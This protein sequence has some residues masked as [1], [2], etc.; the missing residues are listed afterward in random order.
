MPLPGV[1]LSVD[2][3]GCLAIRRPVTADAWL[4]TND[5][6]DLRP[7]GSF[8]WLGRWDNVINSGGV[9]VQVEAV[10]QAI[11]AAGARS[12]VWPLAGRRYGV[13]GLP[14]ERLGQIVALVVEGAASA[15][16]SKT[17]GRPDRPWIALG[18][19]PF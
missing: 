19:A 4:Q 7:D 8:L 15:G 17:V 12:A 5:L 14:E 9:K 16:K 13:A 2:G 18:A 6:V 1:E 3:R 10:E 11:A